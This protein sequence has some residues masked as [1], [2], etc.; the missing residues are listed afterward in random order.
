MR[1]YYYDISTFIIIYANICQKKY[2]KTMFINLII[3]EGE[4]DM[5]SLRELYNEAKKSVID[6]PGPDDTLSYHGFC[7]F[8]DLIGW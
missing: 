3:E 4:L 2:L 6:N 8:I 7:Q 1:F 5:I